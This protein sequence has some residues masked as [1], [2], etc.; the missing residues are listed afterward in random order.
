MFSFRGSEGHRRSGV[1][2][3]A[4]DSNSLC[5]SSLICCRK[6]LEIAKNGSVWGMGGVLTK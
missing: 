3:L 1:N 2:A 5:P 6:A 4:S